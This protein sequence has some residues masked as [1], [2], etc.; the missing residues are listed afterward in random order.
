MRDLLARTCVFL[1]FLSLL[2]T[3]QPPPG[4]PEVFTATL[5]ITSPQEG[6]VHGNPVIPV[7]V[8][9]VPNAELSTQRYN[10]RISFS[11]RTGGEEGGVEEDLDK[12]LL[13]NL[14]PTIN[15]RVCAHLK[16]EKGYMC[17]KEHV[18]ALESVA[19]SLFRPE[20][21]QQTVFVWMMRID[22]EYRDRVSWEGN[23]ERKGGRR[24]VEGRILVALLTI[25][26]VIFTIHLQE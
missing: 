10:D 19:A 4:I 7:V 15:M 22:E 12:E 18:D 20:P 21:G 23:G 3:G 26:R 2:V 13:E 25:T 5:K 1:F 9:L 17:A 14:L 6:G 16:G 24:V 8:Q 11:L